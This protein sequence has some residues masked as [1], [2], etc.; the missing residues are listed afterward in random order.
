[1]VQRQVR[2]Y[3][4]SIEMSIA[5]AEFICEYANKCVEK[6]GSFTIGLSGGTTPARTYSLLA[7]EPYITIM[8]WEKTHVFFGDERFVPPDHPDNNFR[9]ANEHL[10]TKVPIPRHNIFP[11][12]TQVSSVQESAKRYDNLLKEFF[13]SCDSKPTSFDLILL[14]VGTDGHTASLFPS[15]P[16][17]KEK[18][19]WVVSAYAPEYA[20]SRQRI[21][22]TF[23]AI[24][25]SRCALFLCGGKSKK[26]IIGAIIND[27]FDAKLHYP[28][29]CVDTLDEIIWFVDTEGF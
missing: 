8:P 25:M 6:Q 3:A 9:M 15:S 27:E 22:L 14:G 12:D 16:A 5:V 24:N 19:R 11:I 4:S 1:M 10:L 18:E 7:Q 17:L 13:D 20:A 29:A 28:A 21:T 2:E 23:P 26:N